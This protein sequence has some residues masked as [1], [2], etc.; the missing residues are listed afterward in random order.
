[1]KY[2]ISIELLKAFHTFLNKLQE[3]INSSNN[4]KFLIKKGDVIDWTSLNSNCKNEIVI[5]SKKK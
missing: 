4:S 1:M 5:A 2:F 3:G